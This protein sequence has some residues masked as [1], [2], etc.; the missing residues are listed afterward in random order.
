MRQ[1]REVLSEALMYCLLAELRSMEMRHS[2][3]FLNRL[4]CWTRSFPSGLLDAL[5][6]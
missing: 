6:T 3:S 1:V 4:L 2:R 5:A